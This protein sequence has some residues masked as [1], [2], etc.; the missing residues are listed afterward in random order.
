MFFIRKEYEYYEDNYL[1]NIFNEF[2][3]FIS[4]LTHLKSLA[5][6]IILK[7]LNQNNSEK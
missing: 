7:V 1:I 4:N 3:Y 5:N 2:I 6:L